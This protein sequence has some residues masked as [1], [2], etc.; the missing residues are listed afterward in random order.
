MNHNKQRT[1][2]WLA[3]VIVAMWT[4]IGICIAYYVLSWAAG[5]IAR[6]IA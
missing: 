2:A 4:I 5:A 1:E 3:L 6:V